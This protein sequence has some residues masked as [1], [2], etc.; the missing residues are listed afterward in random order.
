MKNVIVACKTLEDELSD[1]IRKTGKSYPTEWLESGL[2]TTPKKLNERLREL[3]SAIE[4][5]RVLLVMG[6]CGNSIEGV[7]AGNFELIIPRVDDCISL[8]IGSMEERVRVSAE[9]AAYFLT[10]GWLR[11]EYNIWVEHEYTVNKYGEETARYIA[12][13]LYGHYRTLGILD[14]GVNAMEPLLEKTKI[15]A[16]TFKLEQKVIPAS[17]AYIRRLL[18]GPWP[19]DRFIVKRPGEEITAKDLYCR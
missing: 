2:H 15:I 6:F 9:N 13:T 19:E 12:D 4:A 3:L 16:D 10:E 11:G 8:L 1:A 17:T 14:S 18:T 5:D 7:K